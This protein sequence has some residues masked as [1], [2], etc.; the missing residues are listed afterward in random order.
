MKSRYLIGIL[1][2]AVIT[3]LWWFRSNNQQAPT[4]P[5]NSLAKAQTALPTGRMNQKTFFESPREPLPTGSIKG[6]ISQRCRD[7]WTD[8]RKMNLGDQ[9]LFAGERPQ[10]PDA[11]QC[12]NLPEPLASLQKDYAEKCAFPSQPTTDEKQK[13]TKTSNCQL[14]SFYYRAQITEYM[15]RDQN[16][17]DI[18]DLRVLTDKLFA[19]FL[20]DPKT[21]V[22]VAERMLE[23]DPTYYPAAQT[24]LLADV[25]TATDNARGNPAD[26]SWQIVQAA[27]D[28]TKRM[29]PNDPQRE[30]MELFMR[31]ARYD[32]PEQIREAANPNTATGLYYLAW[33]AYRSNNP[34]QGWQYLEQARKNFPEDQ[35]VG[36]TMQGVR[37]N[38][39]F[40]LSK[41]RTNSPFKFTVSANLDPSPD[42]N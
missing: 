10:T 13:G 30:E 15:T 8:I 33:S 38:P 42:T 41:D 12:Q 5:E 34:S 26:P 37:Q 28:R 1:G 3:A 19:R 23:L 16:P 11:S 40:Y 18:S 4:I 39:N 17:K 2:L 9:E 7:L 20:T 29:N 36:Q 22:S 21:A 6:S 24:I 32:S 14:A 27:L 31:A 25:L 35:R